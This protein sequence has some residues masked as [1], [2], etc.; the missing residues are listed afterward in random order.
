MKLYWS[1]M[2]IVLGFIGCAPELSQVDTVSEPIV[3]RIE[4]VVKQ[5]E[6][7]TVSNPDNFTTVGK[8]TKTIEA[9]SGPRDIYDPAQDEEVLAAI[10]KLYADANVSFGEVSR[11]VGF[12]SSPESTDAYVNIVRK[13]RQIHYL[14]TVRLGCPRAVDVPCQYYGSLH[15]KKPCP[16]HN[17][18]SILDDCEQKNITSDFTDI[19]GPIVFLP[20]N[21]KRFKGE[22]PT[23]HFTSYECTIDGIKNRIQAPLFIGDNSGYS[24]DETKRL[25]TTVECSSSAE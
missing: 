10:E 1:L 22:N 17:F 3:E 16:T 7:K 12:E 5:Q 2:P 18:G 19:G 11:L 8:P 15:F 4:T 6:I 13:S 25:L 14:D 23:Y 24:L 21:N 9:P 20:K